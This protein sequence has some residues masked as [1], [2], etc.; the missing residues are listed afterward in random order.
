MMRRVPSLERIKKK[1][2]WEP[3]TGLTET[4]QVIIE[5]AK[6]LKLKGIY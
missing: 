3:K 6:K 4:L 2:G 5:E 1:I